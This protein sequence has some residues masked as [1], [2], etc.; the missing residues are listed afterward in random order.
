MQRRGAR[1]INSKALSQHR[2][3]EAAAGRIVASTGLAPPSIVFD[4]GAGDGQLTEALLARYARVVAVEL[5]RALWAQLRERF[6]HDERVQVVL[7]DLTAI[8]LPNRV[9]Y[10]VVSNVPFAITAPL[11]RRLL[12]ERNPPREAYLVLERAAAQKWAGVGFE[13][14]ASILLKNRFR[15][16]VVLGL[17]RTDFLPHPATDSVVVRLLRRERAVFVGR[18]LA[19]FEAFVRRGFGGG[20]TGQRKRADST[21]RYHNNGGRSTAISPHELSFE[22]WAALFRRGR[23]APASSVLGRARR[24]E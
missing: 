5:D 21:A 18:E 22:D 14:Q 15:V 16:D 8:E 13:S 17:R 2:L 23:Y 6:R 4:L 20:L 19:A 3:R 10:K 24:S 7:G 11:M 12:V 9:A 1:P